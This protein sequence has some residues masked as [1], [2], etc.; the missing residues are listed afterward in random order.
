MPTI[1]DNRKAWGEGYD[2]ADGGDEWS[3]AWGG[4]AMQWYG[5]LLPRL[6]NF[7]PAPVILEIAPGFGRWTQFLR[8]HCDRLIGV[9]ITEKCVEHCRKRFAAEEGLEFHVN[10]GSSLHMVTDGSIDLAVSFDSLVHAEEDA[11]GGYAA[12]LARTLA[13]NGV[14]VIHHSNHGS[15][16]D[17]ENPHSRAT[18]MTA[19]RFSELCSLNGLACVGQELID[20]GGSP[21]LIDCISIAAKPGSRWDRQPV[22][23]ENGQFSEEAHRVH[24]IAALYGELGFQAPGPAA[25]PNPNTGVDAP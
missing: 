13:A 21:G 9:D 8:E 19:P 12:E 24:R 3:T 17:L 7:L 6:Q 18:S 1:E 16:P 23:I 4:P 11:I 20:W 14:A 25:G 10:D 15:Y 22:V 5:S 2:W